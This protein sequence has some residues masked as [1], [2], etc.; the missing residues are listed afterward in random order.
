VEA[1]FGAYQRESKILRRAE[2][3]LMLQLFAVLPVVWLR[4]G[5]GQAWPYLLLGVLALHF[6]TIA[7]F[8]MTYG[9]LTVAVCCG[10]GGWRHSR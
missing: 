7:A 5:I 10:I 8:F 9:R 6:W 3:A 2:L 1:R 4:I